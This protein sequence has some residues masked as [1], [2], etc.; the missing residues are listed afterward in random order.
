MTQVTWT[1]GATAPGKT[2]GWRV[3]TKCVRNNW[4]V[5]IRRK[6]ERNGANLLVIV[7]LDGYNYADHDTIKPTRPNRWHKTT[8]GYNVRMSTNSPVDMT[9]QDWQELNY[10]IEQ[11]KLML[12]GFV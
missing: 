9:W 12:K 8:A 2:V 5:E 4:Q 3:E 6:F 11:A 7:G 10:I 1:Q